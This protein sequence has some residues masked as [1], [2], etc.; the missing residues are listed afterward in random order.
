MQ[1]RRKII[2]QGKPFKNVTL[3]FGGGTSLFTTT[4]L[5]AVNFRQLTVRR[6]GWLLPYNRSTAASE[7]HANVFMQASVWPVLF[8][9]CVC[10]RMYVCERGG[11][12]GNMRRERGSAKRDEAEAWR[13]VVLSAAYRAPS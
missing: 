12:V 8:D 7:K 6:A 5:G 1:V 3:D 4:G 13:D 9:R 11:A 10:A 2:I